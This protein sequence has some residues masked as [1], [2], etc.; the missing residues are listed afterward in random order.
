M[1]SRKKNVRCV[2]YLSDIC[3]Q[4]PDTSCSHM[5]RT[6]H[7][8]HHSGRETHMDPL[9]DNKQTNKQFIGLEIIILPFL[10]LSHKVSSLSHL[11]SPESYLI[12]VYFIITM[13]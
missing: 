1:G 8:V 12:K 5:T 2:V 11:D 10:V 4:W 13:N 3:V 6:E 9:R 7:T